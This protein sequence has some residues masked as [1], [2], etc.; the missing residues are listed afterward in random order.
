MLKSKALSD[1]AACSNLLRS[2]SENGIDP[3]RVQLYGVEP[4]HVRHL[5][6][7]QHL[8][9]A[10]DTYPYNGTTTTCESLWMGVPVV[11]LAG[12]LHVSRVGFSMLTTLNLSDLV[13]QTP[14]QYIQIAVAL[15]NDPGRLTELRSTLR[16]RMRR[17]PLMDSVTY[18]HAL[19]QIYRDIW[20]RWCLSNSR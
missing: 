11:T 19:E 17:S 16:D 12:P 15:A 8:D 18:T 20:Q 6:T 3:S 2:C 5:E 9:I 7:Y 10:L 4:A 14:E 13:A 1:S